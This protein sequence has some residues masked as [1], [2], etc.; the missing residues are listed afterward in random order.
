M[1]WLGD[2]VFLKHRKRR[3]NVFTFK[4]AVRTGY[5]NISGYS[6]I[7]LNKEYCNVQ[8]MMGKA[9]PSAFISKSPSVT[10]NREFRSTSGCYSLL[11]FIFVLLPM[12]YSDEVQTES[13]GSHLNKI[14]VLITV[15]HC[16]EPYKS[17]STSSSLL[18]GFTMGHHIATA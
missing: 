11:G 10:R 5:P 4:H 18:A 7:T 12:Y 9:I 1:L 2:N 17:S 8:R 6:R 13:Y 15:L 3:L 16:F 14:T